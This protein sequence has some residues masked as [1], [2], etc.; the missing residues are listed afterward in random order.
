M[1]S[2]N[3]WDNF[4]TELGQDVNSVGFLLVR[5][6]TPGAWWRDDSRKQ[7]N[8]FVLRTNDCLALILFS[9]AA[10]IG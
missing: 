5:T 10:G 1:F 9:F 6:H 3:H 8:G 4:C 2:P 7:H